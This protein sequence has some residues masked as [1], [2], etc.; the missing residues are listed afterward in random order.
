MHRKGVS[1]S[2][3]YLQE[4]THVLEY[5]D[6]CGHTIDVGMVETGRRTTATVF[7]WRG[8]SSLIKLNLH[9]KDEVRE[10]KGEARSFI[11]QTSIDGIIYRGLYETRA[12]AERGENDENYNS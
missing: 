12:E 3:H 4:I 5:A 9:D 8:L 6:M 11:R 10:A 1:R 2:L 7:V